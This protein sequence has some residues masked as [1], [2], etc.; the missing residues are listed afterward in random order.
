VS[1]TPDGGAADWRRVGD[2]FHRALEVPAGEREAFVERESA[3]TPAVKTEVLSLLA[4]HDRAEGFIEQPAAAAAELDALARAVP[5]AERP[6]GP[7]RIKRVLGEGGMGVVYLAEDTRLGREVALKA[8]APR[9]AGDAVRTERL[10][11][12]AR[13]AASLS[14]TGIATVFALDEID[15]HLYLSSEY[16]PGDTLRDVLAHGR[17]KIDRVLAIG[18]AL[19]RALARAHERGIVHRDLKPENVAMTSSGEIKILDFGLAH[20][21]YGGE[22]AALTK[23]GAALGTPSYMSPEQIRGS[24]V[25]ARSDIFSLGVVLYE[26]AT[27]RHPFRDGTTASVVASILED[28]PAPMG[29]ALEDGSDR[30]LAE[31]LGRVI[32]IALAKLPDARFQSAAEMA[33]ALEGSSGVPAARPVAGTAPRAAAAAPSKA[34]WWWRFHQAATT[35][36]YLLL[37]LPVW[38]T[39]SAWSQPDRGMWV[40]LAGVIAVV[41]AGALRLHL[42]FASREYADQWHEQ[43]QRSRRWI[44]AADIVFT[45]VLAAAGVAAIRAEAP[46]VFLVAAAASVAVSFSVIE[47]ATTRAAFGRG[48][49]LP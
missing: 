41:V 30:A 47:P 8:V 6:I 45:S 18:A 48:Q 25:D 20:F 15:G 5:L 13:A 33:A 10:R 44:R 39:R 29:I 43:H 11:R 2:L 19:A 16:V 35:V 26:L 14:H 27:G 21:T 34:L 46:A 38:H 36:A 3:H 9:F 4:A 1:D 7:Y 23:T 42:W 49:V 37:L 12:E 17:L 24:G 40:F 28:E 32:A 31:R 22:G